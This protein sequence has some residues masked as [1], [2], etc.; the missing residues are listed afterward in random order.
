MWCVSAEPLHLVYRNLEDIF[1]T[2]SFC[3]E[4]SNHVVSL[5]RN[6]V[7]AY[8]YSTVSGENS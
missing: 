8:K 1:K 2:C 7:L 5:P 3:G 4:Q 6:S